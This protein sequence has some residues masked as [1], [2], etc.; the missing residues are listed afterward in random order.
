M[1]RRFLGRIP[2]E[3]LVAFAVAILHAPVMRFVWVQTE[4]VSGVFGGPPRLLAQPSLM[5]STNYFQVVQTPWFRPAL[6]M[7]WGAVLRLL[8]PDV[9]RLQ[10]AKIVLLSLSA[11]LV[12]R[13]AMELCGDRLM[14]AAVSVLFATFPLHTYWLLHLC[15]IDDAMMTLFC[16]AALVCL[17]R[18]ASTRQTAWNAAAALFFAG[19]LL[20]KETAIVFPVIALLFNFSHPVEN[21]RPPA[22]RSYAWLLAAAFLWAVLLHAV[23]RGQYGDG[24]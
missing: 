10:C 6:P 24:C 20:A 17:R 9:A 18:A 7:F 21:G 19:A 13:L 3:A 14:A 11:A 12:Y 22:W 8:G 5:F 1:R 15:N 16:L 23:G 4:D 2:I